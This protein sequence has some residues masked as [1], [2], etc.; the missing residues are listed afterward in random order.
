LALRDIPV[1]SPN[2]ERVEILKQ[3]ISK[4]Q[5]LLHK[6]RQRKIRKI[7]RRK[8]VPDRMDIYQ[9]DESSEKK[10]IQ[11]HLVLMSRQGPLAG[12]CIAAAVILREI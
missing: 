5:A 3:V 1:C 4:G 9:H 6:S 10:E 7:K 11:H 2:I 12:P 8:R